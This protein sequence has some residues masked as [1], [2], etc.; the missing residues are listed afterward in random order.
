MVAEPQRYPFWKKASE[1]G[2]NIV[3][4]SSKR[5]RGGNPP[6]ARLQ[7]ANE[8]KDE[9]YGRVGEEGASAPP[10]EHL[11]KVRQQRKNRTCM[12]NPRRT[13]CVGNKLSAGD[14]VRIVGLPDLSTM[15][16]TTRRESAPVF[17]HLKGK[18]KKI[19]KFSKDG[20]AEIEF[21]ILQ[22]RYSGLHTVW[23]ETALLRLKK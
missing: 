22:G 4:F 20:M 10:V 14:L 12:G 21:R 5:A 15:A 16:A 1:L 11:Q 8:E 17:R 7:T 13:D 6:L 18:Y 9:E 2:N 3:L 19:A 23:L